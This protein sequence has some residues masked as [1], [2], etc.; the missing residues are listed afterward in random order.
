MTDNTNTTQTETEDLQTEIS[1]DH[2]KLCLKEY[3]KIDDEIKTLS[4]VLRQ[5]RDRFE[6][7][8]QTLLLFLHKHNINEVQLEGDYAGKQLVSQKQTKTKGA[9]GNSIIDIIKQK[10]GHDNNLLNSILTEIED[11]K[12]TDEVEKIKIATSKPKKKTS[13]KDISKATNDLLM[14]NIPRQ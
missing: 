5:K 12:E 11:I 14:N 7:L 13:H 2:F 8:S 6:T 3:L 9:S 4:A 1:M 10:V